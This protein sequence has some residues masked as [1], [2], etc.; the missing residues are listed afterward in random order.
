[1][2]APYPV[3][4]LTLFPG[5]VSGYLGASILGKAQ[6]KGLLSITVTDLVV[7]IQ[8]DDGSAPDEVH[9]LRGT[10]SVSRR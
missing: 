1:M 8:S 9:A 3:E 10:W 6:E 5:M 4:L 2:S 7:T